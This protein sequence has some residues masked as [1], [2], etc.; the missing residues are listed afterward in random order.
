MKNDREAAA[1]AGFRRK[2]TC[3]HLSSNR[4]SLFP[5]INV[6]QRETNDIRRRRVITWH[7]NNSRRQ[8]HVSCL[9]GGTS[10]YGGGSLAQM[11]TGSQPSV[12]RWRPPCAHAGKSRHVC[13]KSNSAIRCQVIHRW[14]EEKSVDTVG[15]TRSGVMAHRGWGSRSSFVFMCHTNSPTAGWWLT[16]LSGLTGD[17][18]EQV[19][20]Y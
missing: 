5:L 2:E 9:G 17:I 8:S 19:V 16:S 3:T 12:S 20:W 1:S 4:K 10:L 14:V 15:Q 18:T 13:A 11:L 6:F 7:V